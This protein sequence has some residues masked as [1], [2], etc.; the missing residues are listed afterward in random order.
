MSMTALTSSARGVWIQLTE[1]YGSKDE[2]QQTVESFI[3]DADVLI[4]WATAMLR[5]EDPMAEPFSWDEVPQSLKPMAMRG[6]AIAYLVY[7]G[8]G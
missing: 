8:G 4:P 2:A 1:M 5:E 3:E 7:E 6:M